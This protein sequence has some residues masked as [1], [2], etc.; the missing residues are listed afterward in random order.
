MVWAAHNY[1][2]LQKYFLWI[3][4]LDVIVPVASQKMVKLV[5]M[6]WYS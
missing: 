1:R 5:D 4:F 6:L 3:Q 2:I